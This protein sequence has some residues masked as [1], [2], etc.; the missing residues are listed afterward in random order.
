LLVGTY[1]GFDGLYLAL[2]I[3]SPWDLFEVKRSGA[4]LVAVFCRAFIIFPVL[5]GGDI[6][7]GL[8]ACLAKREFC[9]DA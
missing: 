2:F 7:P 9:L 8:D 4:A 1:L 3:C 6:F 5:D